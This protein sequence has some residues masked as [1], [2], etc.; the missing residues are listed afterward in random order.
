MSHT[1]LDC[2]DG[3]LVLAVVHVNDGTAPTY[4]GLGVKMKPPLALMEMVPVTVPAASVRVWGGMP[5]M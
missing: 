2:C 5:G 4:P 1:T 3:L